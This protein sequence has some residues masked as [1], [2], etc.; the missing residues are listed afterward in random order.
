MVKITDN[1]IKVG[2]ATIEYRN[3][4]KLL[5]SLLN[6]E[7]GKIVPDK[8]S[9]K[10]GLIGEFLS[11]FIYLPDV[12]LHH[13]RLV[14]PR[15]KNYYVRRIGEEILYSDVIKNLES[16]N[17]LYFPSEKAYDFAEAKKWHKELTNLIN[18]EPRVYLLAL[19]AAP[20][21][22]RAYR[23]LKK[24]G[25]IDK[26]ISFEKYWTGGADA[27]VQWINSVDI[28]MLYAAIPD[29]IADD[30][31]LSERGVESSPGYAVFL[32]SYMPVMEA[33]YYSHD[34]MFFDDIV[35]EKYRQEW[36]TLSKKLQKRF[37]KPAKSA[38]QIVLEKLSET[39]ESIERSLIEKEYMTE[40]QAYKIPFSLGLL[41][42]EMD[43]KSD[44]IDLIDAAIKKRRER[45][46][47][48]FRK[49]LREYDNEMK[50]IN[51]NRYKL[52]K[53]EEDLNQLAEELQKD[54]SCKILSKKTVHSLSNLATKIIEM[55]IRLKSGDISLVKEIPNVTIDSLEFL[56]SNIC[57]PHKA[58]MQNLGRADIEVLDKLELNRVFGGQGKEFTSILRYYSVV[59]K[60]ADRILKMKRK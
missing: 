48:K 11:D 39:K 41:I 25:F 42:N 31:I 45:G 36:S 8:E 5:K 23:W 6:L 13:D 49:W 55:V 35:K 7:K 52:K 40:M 9:K 3:D 56:Y 30:P 37:G 24:H 20:S 29:N 34:F 4:A 27:V 57:F 59:G 47:K 2:D 50:K 53:M 33:G 38:L 58:Y 21:S 12:L 18:K 19:L 1:D 60:K 10:K 43:K 22:E 46:N 15:P 51:P 14:L 17:I 54:S 16:K 26:N 32:T 28:N 44:P